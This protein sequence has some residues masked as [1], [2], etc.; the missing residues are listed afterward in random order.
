MITKTN[1]EAEHEGKMKFQKK[2]NS[3]D[4]ALICV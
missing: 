4:E 2:F 1:V 3:K